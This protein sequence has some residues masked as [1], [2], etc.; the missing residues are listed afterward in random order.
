MQYGIAKTHHKLMSFN[1]K[2]NSNSDSGMKH[3]IEWKG[4]RTFSRPKT[5]DKA[6]KVKH[7]NKTGNRVESKDAAVD[8]VQRKTS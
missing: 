3:L 5:T 6:V 4:K 7:Q 1:E 2:I 8:K